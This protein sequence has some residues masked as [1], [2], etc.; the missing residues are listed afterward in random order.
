M[1]IK[2]GGVISFRLPQDT[3]NEILNYLSQLKIKTGRTF[4]SRILQIFL[5]GLANELQ[6]HT[7]D[8]CIFLNIP[9]EFPFEK[10]RW[11]QSKETQQYLLSLLMQPRQE[12]P[13]IDLV[14]EKVL[15]EQYQ[16]SMPTNT[17]VFILDNF[18]DFDD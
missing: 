3:S 18:I 6:R 1:A 7:R 14:S 9:K 4:S 15:I 11:L 12:L 5:N 13:N 8:D 2:K 10:K 17:E 16:V